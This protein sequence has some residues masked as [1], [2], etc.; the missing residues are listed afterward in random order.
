MENL[1]NLLSDLTLN[2]IDSSKAQITLSQK[3]YP[4]L[5]FKGHFYRLSNPKKINP[6]FNWRCSL[7]HCNATGRTNGKTIGEQYDFEI[8]NEVH[9]DDSDIESTDSLLLKE[10]RRILKTKA[11]LADEPPRKILNNVA[12]FNYSDEVLAKLPSYEADRLVINREK[13]KSRPQFPPEPSSLAEILIPEPL[14]FTIKGENF[15]LYDSGNMDYERFFIFG[16]RKNLEIFEN[17]HIFCDGTFKVCPKLF[18]QLYT[19]HALVEGCPVPVLYVLLPRKNQAIYEKMLFVIKSFLSKDPISFNVDFE[20][21]FLNAV[22][23]VFPG[24]IVNGCYFHFRKSMR[25]K[26]QDLGLTVDC[27]LNKEINRC[28]KIPN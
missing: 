14:Q 13:K 22:K 19:M 3:K 5:H 4:Q 24:S 20:L 8:L 15:L 17:N 21:A 6:P 10:R 26:I 18:V 16:T 1:S 7:A 28:L 2:N 9:I 12:N 27:R 11:S 25:S 23:K